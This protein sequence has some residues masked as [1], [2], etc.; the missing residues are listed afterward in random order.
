MFRILYAKRVNKDLCGISQIN[1]TR[2]KAAV[3]ELVDFPDIA[4]IKFLKNHSIADYRIRVGDYRVLF[5]VDWER[6][7]IQILKIGHRRNVYD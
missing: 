2:L 4:S 6:G 1:L 3:E 7:E 5:D